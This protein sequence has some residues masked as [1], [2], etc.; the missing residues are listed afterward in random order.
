M[1][2]QVR[3]NAINQDDI[4]YVICELMMHN[5]RVSKKAIKNKIQNGLYSHGMEYFTILEERHEYSENLEVAKNKA[6]TYV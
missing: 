4:A 2:I 1:N 3:F 6:E 5:D